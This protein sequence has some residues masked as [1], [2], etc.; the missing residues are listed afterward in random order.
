MYMGTSL[1]LKQASPPPSL[2]SGLSASAPT[3]ASPAAVPSAGA[4]EMH[5][6]KSRKTEGPIKFYN[7]PSTAPDQ[8]F[9]MLLPFSKTSCIK[10]CDTTNARILT[11]TASMW[12]RSSDLTCANSAWL[13]RLCP[14]RRP[15]SSSRLLQR[16]QTTIHLYWRI[17]LAHERRPAWPIALSINNHG[18][19]HC[20]EL[21][22]S[23]SPSPFWTDATCR[24][25]TSIRSVE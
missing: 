12:L 15:R 24:E 10:A 7:M 8:M 19:H 22:S 17:A 4:E 11:A 9:R 23:L 6:A 5:I 13:T 2:F 21:Q 25:A 18:S 16:L 1:P 3:G 20:N 14:R